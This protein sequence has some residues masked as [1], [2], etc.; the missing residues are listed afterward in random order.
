MET[1]SG[2]IIFRETPETKYLLLRYGTNRLF[3]VKGSRIVLSD[4]H[5]DYAW[6]NYSHARER[7]THQNSKNVLWKAQQ[8]LKKRRGG[9][10]SPTAN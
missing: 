3:H 2:A 9:E 10:P 6:L 1:S 8:T 4:E 5:N 7:L